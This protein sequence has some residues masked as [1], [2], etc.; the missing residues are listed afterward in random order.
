MLKLSVRATATRPSGAVKSHAHSTLQ[1][2]DHSKRAR[3]RSD[4]SKRFFR[5]TVDR[6]VPAC[7]A[8]KR[9]GVAQN[10]HSTSTNLHLLARQRHGGKTSSATIQMFHGIRVPHMHSR[11]L[12][13]LL[14]AIRMCGSSPLPR[15]LGR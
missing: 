3:H 2:G 9:I 5:S 10:K 11:L 14:I 12:T 8:W 7:A 15:Y 6:L 13:N 4:V 1:P